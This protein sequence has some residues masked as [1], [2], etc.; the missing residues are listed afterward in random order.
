MEAFPSSLVL[1]GSDCLEVSMR[2][3]GSHV[4][5]LISIRCSEH[6]GILDDNI[7]DEHNLKCVDAL[8]EHSKTR[9]NSL[10]NKEWKFLCTVKLFGMSL[11]LL[12][13]TQHYTLL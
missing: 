2:K 5:D 11:I 1:V 8:L 7:T 3:D 4:C 13:L 12:S 6:L 9:M 10:N